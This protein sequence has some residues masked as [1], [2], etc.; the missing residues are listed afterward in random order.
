MADHW[1]EGKLMIETSLKRKLLIDL[2][3]RTIDPIGNNRIWKKMPFHLQNYYQTRYLK[4]QA[5][6]AMVYGTTDTVID[7]GDLDFLNVFQPAVIPS[8]NYEDLENVDFENLDVNF[9]NDDID[10][11]IQPSNQVVN[12]APNHLSGQSAFIS[13]APNA[14]SSTERTVAHNATLPQTVQNSNKMKKSCMSCMVYFIFDQKMGIDEAT[15]KGRECCGAYHPKSCVN[16]QFKRS[17]GRCYQDAVLK[18]ISNAESLIIARI[19]NGMYRDISR[20]KK[21]GYGEPVCNLK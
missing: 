2:N 1:N 5:R 16:L 9:M 18:G 14:S 6:K 15:I 12:Q 20:K 13:V 3:L 10:L 7:T 21:S 17:C 19:C 11:T 8:L 4:A